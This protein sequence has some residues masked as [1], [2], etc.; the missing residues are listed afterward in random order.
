MAQLGSGAAHTDARSWR[1]GTGRAPSATNGVP[2]FA[3]GAKL[4]PMQSNVDALQPSPAP[5]GR[6]T[7]PFRFW[8][9]HLSGWLGYGVLSYLSALAHG[10]PAYYIK[11]TIPL[12]IAGVVLTW[13][14]REEII[15][16]EGIGAFE[17]YEAIGNILFVNA[18][19][20][21]SIK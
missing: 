12:V 11:V 8:L 19:E 2:V 10:K 5:A 7:G 1:N 16:H 20:E 6:V 3:P 14:L 18:S 13:A 17:G 21:K 4:P 15:R 9:L